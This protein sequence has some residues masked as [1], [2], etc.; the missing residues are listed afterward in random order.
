MGDKIFYTTVFV[1]LLIAII[2]IYFVVSI[3]L[4]HRRY[5]RLQRERITAE[6]TI[7]ENE[8]K[9]IA[10][11]LH[12]S[13]GPL[14]STVKLILNSIDVQSEHDKKI[15]EKSSRYIDETITN[16]RQISHNLLPNALE[17][18]GLVE[19]TREFIQQVS[20]QQSLAIELRC[21]GDIRVQPEKAIHI[22]RIIQEII[23]N[24]LKHARASQL[25]I[26]LSQDDGQLLL[27]VRENGAGFDVKK[28]K[29]TSAGLGMKSLEIRT[30]IMHGS[31]AIESAP[32]QGT[33]YFI[34]I[35]A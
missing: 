15:I 13:A 28:A 1:S 22:F 23:Q 14:L 7:L 34:K 4:Y 30:D 20:E 11:D 32:G 2:I 18:K 3:I 26:S 17:R 33:Q 31:L 10:T 24:T 27:L 16:L 35:P 25:R 12:D 6:I 9:R 8:R 21:N 29:T 5:I 19:A